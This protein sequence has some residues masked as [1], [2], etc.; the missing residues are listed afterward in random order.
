MRIS[1]L[2]TDEC[3]DGFGCARYAA[4]VKHGR[5]RSSER[6]SLGGVPRVLGLELKPPSLR[7]LVFPRI[8]GSIGGLSLSLST[9][10]MKRVSQLDNVTTT[11]DLRSRFF[12]FKSSS[13]DIWF[14]G[15]R[16]VAMGL[17]SSSPSNLR[18]TERAVG[19]EGPE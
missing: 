15:L 5:G 11:L 12:A 19:K 2:P 9:L 8:T 16:S 3:E 6:G 14:T 17:H 1:A 4:A 13:R 7:H 18:Q 10:V